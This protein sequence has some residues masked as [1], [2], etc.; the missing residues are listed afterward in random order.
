MN[1]ILDN[2]CSLLS[3][4]SLLLSGSIHFFFYIF[5]IFSYDGQ[6]MQKLAFSH[7]SAFHE[8]KLYGQFPSLS[9]TILTFSDMH[10]NISFFKVHRIFF[11]FL[12]G[13][14]IMS[15]TR[16]FLWLSCLLWCHAHA[17]HDI[18]Q[19]IP[20]ISWQSCNC[21]RS[22]QREVNLE[23]NPQFTLAL[24]LSHVM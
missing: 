7:W 4:S 13:L 23:L 1:L 14:K 18:S 10:S 21:R 19:K 17:E 2:V 6:N 22:S 15:N 24:V 16:F 11:F 9:L 8:I 20:H 5:L 3:F 12:V